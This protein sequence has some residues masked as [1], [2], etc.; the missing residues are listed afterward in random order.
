M[1]YGNATEEQYNSLKI[2]MIDCAINIKC[3][4]LYT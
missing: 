4:K 3:N 2:N 1:E